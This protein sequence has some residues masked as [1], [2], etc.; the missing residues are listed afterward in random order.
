MIRTR[1]E[2]NIRA[3]NATTVTVTRERTP[4]GP[5]ISVT[6]STRIYLREPVTIRAEEEV[7]L[8]TGFEWDRE[9]WREWWFTAAWVSEWIRINVRICD[10]PLVVSVRNHHGSQPFVLTEGSPVGSLV[11]HLR[12]ATPPFNM[13]S[14]TSLKFQQ[15]TE[16]GMV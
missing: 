14:V 13:T 9:E 5:A 10:S 7:V 15:D 12:Y 1:R 6:R 3:R 8:D 2:L 11:R 4:S 16:G